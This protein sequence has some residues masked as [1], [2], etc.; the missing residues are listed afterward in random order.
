MGKKTSITVQGA[1]SEYEYAICELD[2]DTQ[3]WYKA[4]LRRFAEWCA[5][6]RLHVG[7]LKPT[8]ISAYLQELRSQPSETTGKPLATSTLH[9]HM[10]TIKTFL[11]WCARPP[12][13]YLSVEV[14]QN[15]VMPK[16]DIT[17]IQPFSREQIKALEVTVTQNHFPIM[18]ARD[19]AILTV[20]LDTGMRAEELCTLTL[21]NVHITVK[22]GYVL[23]MGKGRKQR[24]VPLGRKSR[25][26]LDQYIK[27][28]RPNEED[29]TVFLSH[30]HV[31]L[32]TN[33]LRQM[34]K[35]WGRRAKITGV[36][37]SPHTCR[38]TYAINFLLQG[39]DLAILSRLLGHN[40]LATTEI[41]LRAMQAIQARKQG[42]SVM[43]HL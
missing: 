22:E 10:R 24:E 29:P 18:V 20:L 35:R 23:I 15:L 11:F 34:F 6:K 2:E 41:Y 42:K 14:P 4:R 1:F 32:T 26:L 36:R 25:M 31:P 17:V 38:H 40:S 13:R 39:G 21:E 27:R 7:E 43:D 5:R 3:I 19:K 9:G 33:A 12:Q 37:C 8:H 30:E 16:I 28:F